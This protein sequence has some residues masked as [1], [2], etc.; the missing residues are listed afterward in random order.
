MEVIIV[1][2]RHAFIIHVAKRMI[3]CKLQMNSQIALIVWCRTDKLNTLHN[4][5]TAGL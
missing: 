1:S 4:I 3:I 2:L 5:E